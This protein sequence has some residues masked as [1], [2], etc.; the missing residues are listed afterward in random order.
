M[1]LCSGHENYV[2]NRELSLYPQSLLAKL[3]VQHWWQ[4]W[5]NSCILQLLD[6]FCVAFAPSFRCHRCMLARVRAA[7]VCASWFGWWVHLCLIVLGLLL[8]QRTRLLEGVML[9][10]PPLLVSG[11]I[12]F[13]FEVYLLT[14]NCF[15]LDLLLCNQWC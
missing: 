12:F 13:L 4:R 2:V 9:Y 14:M 15:W 5:W 8:S 11:F 3:T 1:G 6:S 7:V 10:L